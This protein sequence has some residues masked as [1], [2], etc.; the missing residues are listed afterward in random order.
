MPDLD[1]LQHRLEEFR[2]TGLNLQLEPL[3]T[4]AELDKFGVEYQTELVDELEQ[5]IEDDPSGTGKQIFTGHRGCGKSTLLAELGFRLL[6]T[7]RYFIVMF[8]IA[9][10]IERSAVDHVNILFSTAVE[11]LESAEE[12]GVKLKPGLKRDLFRWLGKHT[13]TESAAVEAAI[14]ASGEASVKGGLPLVLEFLAKIKSTLKVNSVVRQEI[15]TEFARKTS[16]LIAR[17]NEIQIYLENATGLKVLVII[18]DL[19]K[20]D[21][22][23]TESIFSKNI[24]PLLD[25]SFRMLYTI[26]IATMQ[27]VKIK[28][29]IESY[30]T[31][32]HV[33]P[34]AKFFSRATVRRSDRI[35]DAGMVAIFLDVLD[36]RLPAAMIEPELRSQIVLKS[37]GVLRELVRIMDLCGAVC[38]QELRRQIRK[39]QFDQPEVKITS[40][41][42]D[43]ILGDLQINYA[44]PLGQSDY[45]LLKRI[46]D[47]FSP[48]KSEDPRF[49]TLLHGLYILEY[50]N[51]SRWHDLNPLMVDLLVQ[52][53]MISA[54]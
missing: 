10:T 14:E 21:L 26:P 50:R 38:L 33:M 29:M 30:V 24:Q 6:E 47:E 18:D 28:S 42:L 48:P 49:L 23:V 22:S 11:L 53:G 43:K 16:D 37:G 41:V 40:A 2:T 9:D 39:A 15:S 3:L 4:R 5:A 36:R 46:Y 25:P 31:K 32:I 44:T 35:P 45:E 27:E 12:Q 54:A 17:L 7:K 52:N 20:L 34:V 19:D 1:A 13:Q 51:A 8:S